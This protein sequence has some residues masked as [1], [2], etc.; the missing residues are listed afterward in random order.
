MNYILEN[1]KLKVSISDLGAELQSIYGK[2]TCFEYLWQGSDKFWRNKA[3]NVFPNCGRLYDGKYTYNGNTYEL[4]CHGFAGKSLFA[5]DYKDNNKI[6]F[7]LSS[8]EETKKVYPFSFNFFVEYTL[9]ENKLTCTYRVE[10]TGDEDLPF[11]LGG[12]PGFNVPLDDGIEFDEHYLEFSEKCSPTSLD[13][14]ATCFYVGTQ[15]PFNLQ[16][17]KILKLRHEM[18]DNDAVFLTNMA[19][20]VTLKSNKTNRYVKVNYPQMTH[21]G[22]WHNPKTDAPFVCIEPWNGVPGLDQTN[23]DFSNK[24]EFTHLDSKETYTNFFE[25]QVNE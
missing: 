25:I 24:T 4:P 6:T 15:S 1:D 13:L 23:E 16:D 18:F 2:T 11:S 14:S 12:H 22:F 21:L 8:N 17:G 20:S 19:K 5:I 10:N 7:R 3:T 9:N